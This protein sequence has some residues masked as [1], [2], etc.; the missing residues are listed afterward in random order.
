MEAV[1]RGRSQGLGQGWRVAMTWLG[2]SSGRTWLVA[3]RLV[4]LVRLGPARLVARGR[5]GPA[6]REGV[7]GIEM[8]RYVARRRMGMARFI[9]NSA[10]HVAM[11]TASVG[12]SR[13][14]GWTGQGAACRTGADGDNSAG[15]VAMETAWAGSA[16]RV[17]PGGS[18]KSRGPVG[19]GSP[20]S[21][22]SRRSGVGGLVA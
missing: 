3:A 11:E 12:M 4:D 1:E 16:C 15:H 5:L 6:R 7:R 10:G 2:T 22:T 9:T 21:G 17:G 14:V 8:A 19:V 13:G 18:G 20:R